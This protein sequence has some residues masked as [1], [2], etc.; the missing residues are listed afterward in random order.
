MVS[1][2]VLF[3]YLTTISISTTTSATPLTNH[4]HNLITPNTLISDINTISQA[5]QSLTYT[6]STLS[7]LSTHN[8]LTL[9]TIHLTLK[10]ASIHTSTTEAYLDAKLISAIPSFDSNRIVEYTYSNVG[11]EIPEAIRVLKSKKEDFSTKFDLSRIVLRGLKV[12]RYDYERFS[13]ALCA[14]LTPDVMDRA[15]VMIGVIDTALQDGI[16]YFSS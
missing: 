1:L 12:L 8:N 7:A 13:K 4:N 6:L 5:I 9:S 15:N 14:K 11:V 16:D 3:T 10:F 2:K